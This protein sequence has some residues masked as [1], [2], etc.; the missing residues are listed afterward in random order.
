MGFF[1]RLFADDGSA[2]SIGS[3]QY[4]DTPRRQKYT[5]RQIRD[6]ASGAE[7]RVRGTRA[8]IVRPSSATGYDRNP[9]GTWSAAG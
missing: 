8:V 5:D 3:S 7:L 2:G 1:S 4:S 6:M 9:D